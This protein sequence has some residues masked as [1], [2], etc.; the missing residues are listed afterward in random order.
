MNFIDDFNRRAGRIDI[1]ARGVL[2][3]RLPRLCDV[4]L[5]KTQRPLLSY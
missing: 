2:L 4:Q 3:L 1:C 5:S